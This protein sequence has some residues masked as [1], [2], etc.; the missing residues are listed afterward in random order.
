M[1][2]PP[3]NDFLRP[4]LNILSAGGI[5]TRGQTLFQLGK[6]FNISEEEAQQTSGRQ[7]TLVNRVA[8][9]DAH[10][11]KAGFVT[12]QQSSVDSLQDRF[13]ITALGIRELDR[14]ADKLTVGYLQSFYKGKI[15]RGAGSDDTTSDAELDLYDAFEQ[16]PSE[17]TVFHSVKWFAKKGG[18]VGEIDFIIAHPTYGLLVIEVKGGEVFTK[19][20]GNQSRWYSRDHNGRIHEIN[21]P[22]GQAERNRRALSDWLGE[23]PRTKN[24]RYAIFPAVALPDS[25]VD[26]DIRPDCP[27]D[28]FIDIR[29]LAD[30]KTRLL[31]IFSYWKAHADSRNAFM[32]GQPGITALVNLLVPTRQL[33]PR[34]ADIFERE[35]HKID[36]LTQTQFR[37]LRQ[38]RSHKR[39]AI[40]GGAGSGKTML[41]MEKAHQLAE[42][43]FRVLFVC[44]N[45]GLA[46]W[47]GRNLNDPGILVST[48]H[49]LVGHARRWARIPT[50]GQKLPMD[51]FN[52]RAPDLLLDA[53]S[54]I[55]SP[56]SG[57]L[58]SLFDALIVD[59]A[60][61][62]EETWW[63][64][65]P[66][67]LHE[68]KTGVFYVFFDNNQRL[69]KQISNIAM[70]VEPFYLDENCRNTRHIHEQMIRYARDM[71][72]TICEGP[73][74]RPVEII[75]APDKAAERREL[76]KVL[77]RLIHEQGVAPA[78]III[79]TPASDKRSVWKEG[80]TIGNF[81]LTYDMNTQS[82]GAIRV[83]TIYRFKGLESAVVILTEL[84][85][86]HADFSN[87]L[88][89]VGLSRARH[90]AIVI[91]ELPLPAPFAS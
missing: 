47:V 75:P 64:V 50:T 56:D 33:Q 26:R 15:F 27:R 89:Y 34:V 52:E 49:G 68:P 38:L 91:G 86:R 79:L 13:Q 30:L 87:Q 62:F 35:R 83:C 51:E 69:Y 58:D 59:E 48:F 60:Q 22:C 45:R 29:H 7:F 57:A 3:Q 77:H 19:P 43:G 31:E 9:C 78:D 71:E 10:F 32:S 54:I 72:E 17:F 70:E 44:F 37:V 12:K 63:L 46:E 28:I 18:T 53:L 65:L 36:E 55:R 41:A 8:W 20:D 6:H 11:V 67:L 39:A 5:Q 16:L 82:D 14:S 80:D 81:F 85:K 24:L 74:G 66:D 90:H 88:V 84:D 42:A 61:D 40:V 4:F 2:I 23:D 76:G 25:R 21:D 1:P 73:E